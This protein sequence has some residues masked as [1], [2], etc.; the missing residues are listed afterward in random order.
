[1]GWVS[2]LEDKIERLQDSIRFMKPALDA[3]EAPEKDVRD[4]AIKAVK[5]AEALLEE[6]QAHLELATSPELDFAHEIKA[7]QG[8][9]RRLECEVRQAQGEARR[10]EHEYAEYYAELQDANREIKSLKK[11][12]RSLEKTIDKIAHENPGA[13]LDVYSTPGMMKKH[14]PGEGV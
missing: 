12:N 13:A 1:M 7:L 10:I 4:K 5:D 2:Y 3:V 14:K 6:A 9:I 8:E 11:K